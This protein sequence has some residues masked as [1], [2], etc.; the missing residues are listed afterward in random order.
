MWSDKESDIDYLNFSEIAESIADIIN[1]PELLPL[2]IGVF[3]DWGAGKSTILSLTES[4]LAI[5]N[6][7]CLHIKFDAWLYQGYDDARASILE[8]IATYL[9]KHTKYNESLCDKAKALYGRVNKIRALG[10]VADVGAAAMGIPTF[11]A[12]GKLFGSAQEV[13]ESGGEEDLDINSKELKAAGKEASS[14]LKPVMKKSP[15][16]EISAFRKQY[17]SLIKEIGKPI[18]VYV[19]NLDRCTPINAIQTLEAIRLFLFLPN[20]AFVIAADEEMIRSAVREYHKGATDRHQTDYLDKLIQ[21]PVNVPKPG[22][23]EIRAY[24]YMLVATDHGLSD[25]SLSSMRDA[26]EDSL[27]NSWKEPAIKVGD[28]IAQLSDDEQQTSLEQLEIKLQAVNRMATILANS[29]RI[30]GNPRIVK[31]LLNVVRMRKKVSDRRQMNLEE[32]LITK[33]VIFERCAGKQATTELYQLID[34]EKGKPKVFA[35]LE[36]E[37]GN[38]ELPTAWESVKD[39]VTEWSKI[40]PLLSDTDLRAAAYL[41]RETIPMGII[42]SSISSAGKALVELLLE[43]EN[44]SSSIAKET[45]ANTP[46]EDYLAVMEEL[47]ENLRQ[48]SD[49]SR[50]PKGFAG[51][52]IL[53]K[54][55]SVCKQTL[56]QFISSLPKEKWM[57]PALKGIE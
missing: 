3:G 27:R 51:A 4:S 6:E 15:P 55:D 23:L 37:N 30:N 26:L 22:V 33:L 25:E 28:L 1:S 54:K 17:S 52:M 32:S 44:M 11:G 45:V 13:I 42:N 34:K 2:S 56:K 8:S 29:P 43:T 36:S 39:F 31:R 18:V 20:T 47:L 12:I 35:E 24:L 57:A 49:W 21:V 16:Q 10:A 40:P 5:S 41:S 50:K 46:Q 14:I 19:D 53:A 48:I 38:A 9:V 7:D